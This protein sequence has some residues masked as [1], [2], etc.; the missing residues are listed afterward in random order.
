MAGLIE[1]DIRLLLQRKALLILF[2]VISIVVGFAKDGT[3]IL[4]YLPFLTAMILMSTI[5]YDELDNG[6]QFLMTLPI[7]ERLYVKEKYVFC[8]GGT[9]LAWVLAVI[10]YMAAQIS[11]GTKMVLSEQ[12]LEFLMFLCVV[13]FLMAIMLPVQIKFGAERGRIVLLCVAGGAAAVVALITGFVNLSAGNVPLYL[14]G[15]ISDS[16]IAIGSV[17]VTLLVLVISYH[18]SVKIM[19]KKEF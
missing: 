2:F 16:V 8:M 3:F 7:S 5:S 10:L 18:A 17:V 19:E 15:N 12:A 1:K 14:A 4:G 11:S 13:C 6:Y 9:A